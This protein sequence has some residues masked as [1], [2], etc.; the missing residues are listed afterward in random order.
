MAATP[1]TP[2]RS[3]ISRSLAPIRWKKPGT[4]RNRLKEMPWARFASPQ[5]TK[6]RVKS[7]G[8]GA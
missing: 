4:C 2:E 8:R 7:R 3:P 1:V 5:N 6:G